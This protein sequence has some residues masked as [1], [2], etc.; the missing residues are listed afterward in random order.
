MVEFSPLVKSRL[1]KLDLVLVSIIQ[2]LR[3]INVTLVASAQY[4]PLESIY[5]KCRDISKS[6]LLGPLK[7]GILDSFLFP[8]PLDS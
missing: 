1:K 4:F 2:D 8:R 7:P 6:F 5:L 3:L